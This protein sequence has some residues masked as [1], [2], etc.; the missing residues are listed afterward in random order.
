MI[1]N[2]LIAKYYC[3]TKLIKWKNVI[4]DNIENRD[5]CAH[6]QNFIKRNSNRVQMFDF[7]SI[8]KNKIKIN[9]FFEI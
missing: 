4:M 5:E 6:T 3:N 9:N 8:Y 1:H 7:K 2:L